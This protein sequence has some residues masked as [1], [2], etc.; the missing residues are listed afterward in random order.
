MDKVYAFDYM[1]QLFLE[2]R[3]E[4][5]AASSLYSGTLNKLSVLK[6]LFLTAVPHKSGG[7]DLLDTFDKFYA[8][9][10][11][12]VESDIYNAILKDALPSYKLTDTEVKKKEH[13]ALPYNS[14][15][16]SK[17]E[18]AVNDL[19]KINSQL[20]LMRAFQLVDITHR[21]ESWKD[22][23]EFAKFMDMYSYRMSVD[24]IR[25]DANRYFGNELH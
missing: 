17:V 5:L 13:V 23:Y 2:W 21:W 16:Y 9:P 11:G 6:L 10:Y 1:L 24:S 3:K 15:D 12:P 18:D 8:L 4:F 7:E 22:A 19:R 14:S 25:N 20:I